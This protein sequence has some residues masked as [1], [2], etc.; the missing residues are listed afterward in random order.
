MMQE[1][2]RNG[3]NVGY[4]PASRHDFSKI[5]GIELV[6]DRQEVEQIVSDFL[7]SKDPKDPFASSEERDAIHLL[8]QEQD[9]SFPEKLAILRMIENDTYMTRS[10]LATGDSTKDGALQQI[11]SD[12]LKKILVESPTLAQTIITMNKCGGKN[13]QLT[14]EQA[15]H[16]LKIPGLVFSDFPNGDT[17]IDDMKK[18]S[19]KIIAFG[20]DLPDKTL[21]TLIVG[22]NSALNVLS[23][24]PLEVFQ[25]KTLIQKISDFTGRNIEDIK[26]TARNSGIK[27]Y[28][29][30]SLENRTRIREAGLIIGLFKFD[31]S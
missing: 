10:L 15:E 21:E 5:S 31:P 3:G 8:M 12:E 13:N 24:K 2:D 4:S 18:R 29:G 9:R 20:L 7:N 22:K 16:M 6:Q 28:N 26:E 30:L 19:Y 23:K 1:T 17:V 25:S 27:Y 14:P 11:P